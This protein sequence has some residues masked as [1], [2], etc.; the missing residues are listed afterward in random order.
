[1][2]LVISVLFATVGSI[3]LSGVLSLS[4]PELQREGGVMR[5]IRASGRAVSGIFIGEG[6]IGLI[7]WLVA[8]PFSIPLGMLFSKL[9]ADATDF[10]FG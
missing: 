5:A 10:Q 6:L 8:L 3:G 1:M 4:A 9:I 2:L 7:N